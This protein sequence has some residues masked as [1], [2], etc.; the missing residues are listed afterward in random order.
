MDF[1]G[2]ERSKLQPCEEEHHAKEDDTHGARQANVTIS[3]R[4]VIEIQRDDVDWLHGSSPLGE[5]VLGT[6]RFQALEHGHNGD[7]HRRGLQERK[8][9]IQ[10]I[11]PS[12]CTIRSCS[13]MDTLGIDPNP[14]RK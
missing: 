6:E 14:T 10:E 4:G 13:F 9:D 1:L 11:R 8:R 2:S 3:D 7:E 12:G 5:E